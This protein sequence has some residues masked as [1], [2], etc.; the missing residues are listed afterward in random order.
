MSVAENIQET[1]KT[2]E[3]E[4]T[5]LEELEEEKSGAAPEASKEPDVEEA[6]APLANGKTEQAGSKP[7]DTGAQLEEE[8]W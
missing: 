3:R 5:I 8:T 6:A 2:P 7:A 1:P 4:A